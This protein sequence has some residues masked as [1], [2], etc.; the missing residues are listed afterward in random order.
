MVPVLFAARRL[1]SPEPLPT[2]RRS[3]RGLVLLALGLLLGPTVAVA[4]PVGGG[5]GGPASGAG[6]RPG[7]GWGGPGGPASG[8]G[9]RPG[10]GWGAP[11]PGLTRPA[12]AVGVSRWSPAWAGGAYWSARPWVWGWYRVNPVVWSWWPASAALW[13]IGGLA[14]AA[15]LTAVVNDAIAAQSTVIVVPQTTLRLDYGSVRA[16]RPTGVRFAWASGDGP[17]QQAVADCQSG[18]L[19]GAPPADAARA[20]LL[21]AACQ[22]AYGSP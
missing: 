21:N 19:D 22:V 6:V 1:P 3:R 17:F 11:G 18:L 10:A 12:G 2:R 4:R 14:S 13:G 7:A 20:Q 9:V 16:V 5:F 15:T 8:A